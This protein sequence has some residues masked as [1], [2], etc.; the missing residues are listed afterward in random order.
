M[1]QS[2]PVLP[3]EE[4][5]DKWLSMEIFSSGYE[6]QPLSSLE[7]NKPLTTEILTRSFQRQTSMSFDTP[8]NF[9]CGLMNTETH[10]VIAKVL[11][12]LVL[13]R[14]QDILIEAGVPQ[15]NQTAYRKMGLLC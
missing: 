12:S 13:E 3:E 1:V 2:I 9:I 8:R 5:S 15:V 6:T 4:E 10:S 11:E 14:M 7:S